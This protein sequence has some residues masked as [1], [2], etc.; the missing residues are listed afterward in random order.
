MKKTLIAGLLT[1]PMLISTPSW[2]DEVTDQMSEALKAYEEKD[3]KAAIDELKYVTIALQK[4]DQAEN[5]KLLPEPLEGWTA[6]EVDNNDSQMA[7]SI[8]GGGSSMKAGY[9]RETEQVDIEIMANSPMMAMMGMMINNPALASSEKG[10]EAYRYKR[11]KG[12][13][14]V[15][16]DK[17]EITL[18]L[19]GQ[20]MIKVTGQK[21]QDPAVLE[22]Y[23]DAMDMNKLKASLL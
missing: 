1:L 12:I 10:T 17:T 16:N 15:K 6:K 13:K 3:Y 2:A 9:Q 18:L 4:L 7:M 5:Q 11:I 20:I 8:L 14:K 23:L 19:A 22:Q 21:L